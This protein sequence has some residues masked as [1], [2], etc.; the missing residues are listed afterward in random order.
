MKFAIFATLLVS[1][2]AFSIN[3]ADVAKV[4]FC[5]LIM[6]EKL[7]TKGTRGVDFRQWRHRI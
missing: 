3:K 7:N 2:S 6:D 5:L 4:R 1:A